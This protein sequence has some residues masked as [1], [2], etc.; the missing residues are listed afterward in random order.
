[1]TDRTTKSVR[2]SDDDDD[3][4]DKTERVLL[5]AEFRQQLPQ[6]EEGRTRRNFF[7]PPSL[8]FCLKKNVAIFIDLDA[9]TTRPKQLFCPFSSHLPR[10]LQSLG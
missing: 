6:M 4:A 7:P 2:G 3:D 1:M 9:A 10:Y 8:Y 5:E